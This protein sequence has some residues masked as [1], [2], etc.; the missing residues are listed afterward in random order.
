MY[1]VE[2]RAFRKQRWEPMATFPN[3]ESALKAAGEILEDYLPTEYSTLRV[4]N[5]R[6]GEEVFPGPL[7]ILLG[8][9][10]DGRPQ[11]GKETGR[12]QF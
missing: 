12:G 7:T 10:Q 6:T 3:R 8:G 1:T 11:P 9:K 4:V 2:A 5:L